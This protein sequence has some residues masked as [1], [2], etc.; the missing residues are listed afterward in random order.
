[1]ECVVAV[2]NNL[3]ISTEN[4][5]IPWKLPDDLKHFKNLTKDHIVIMGMKTY[6]S[7]PIKPL[8][9]RTNIVITHQPELYTSDG[10]LIFMTYNECMAHVDELETSQK[11]F[12]IG[13]EDIYKLFEPHITV[14]HMTQVSHKQPISFNKFFFKI[15]NTFELT[16]VSPMYN[17]NETSFRFLKYTLAENLVN[18]D[19]EYIQLSKYILENGET[20]KDRTNTGT[21]SVFAQQMKFDIQNTIPI[22]TTKRVPWKSCIEELLWFLTGNTN[23]ND[24]DKIGVKIWNANSSREFLDNVGLEHLQPGDCGANYSFQ[25]RHFGGSYVDFNHQYDNQGVDQ[26]AYIEHLLKHDKYSRR[27]FLSAWNPSDLKNTVLP[28]CHVSAQFYVDNDDYLHCHMYQRSCDMFLG[29]PWNILSYSVLTYIFAFRNDLKPG[30]L[31][32]STGDTHIYNNHIEQM[33]LQISRSSLCSPKLILNPKI[34]NLDFSEMSSN[35]F[36]LVGY[37][38]HPTIKGEMSA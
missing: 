31:T 7:L 38:P 24:L 17:N 29:V 36:D 33:K 12:V 5:D 34:K 6:N 27:I 21:I 35:D 4:D 32:M 9:D 11:Y 1:M 3:G 22:L 16:E 10:S 2:G 30:S 25:W 23:A 13:G 37:F 26:I 19:E 14:I 18:H 20:R 15:P 8:P 28:P